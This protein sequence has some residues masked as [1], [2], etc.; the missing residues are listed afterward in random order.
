[1]GQL[2]VRLERA[3]AVLNTIDSLYVRDREPT[4]KLRAVEMKEIRAMLGDL[5]EILCAEPSEAGLEAMLKRLPIH[6]GRFCS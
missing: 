6:T 4:E 2:I 1:V 5:C 3:Q